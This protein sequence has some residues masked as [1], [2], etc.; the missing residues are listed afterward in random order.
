MSKWEKIFRE[1]LDSMES[2]GI[3]KNNIMRVMGIDNFSRVQNIIGG[4]PIK[5]IDEELHFGIIR[6]CEYNF[7][8]GQLILYHGEK[9]VVSDKTLDDQLLEKLLNKI[10]ILLCEVG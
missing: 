2:N 10:L 5:F 9:V 3:N 4:E 7:V 8:T 6:H 1:R